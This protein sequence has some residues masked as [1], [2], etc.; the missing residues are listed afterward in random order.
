MWV[1]GIKNPV[2]LEDQPVFSTPPSL[3]KVFCTVL[4][5]LSISVILMIQRLC[6]KMN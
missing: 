3:F 5:L 4:I 1:L 2:S 6:D